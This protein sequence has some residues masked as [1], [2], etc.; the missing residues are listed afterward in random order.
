[1]KKL[2]ILPLVL[3]SLLVGC[4]SKDSL[5]KTLS[6]NPDILAE[7][8]KANPDE[9]VEALNEAFKAAQGSQGKKREEEEKKALEKSFE[10]PLI[11]EIRSDEMIRGSKDG[12]IVVVEY[13]DFE[14]PFCGR[15]Y[16]TVMELMDKYKGKVKFIYKHLPLSFHPNAM[17]A[18][19]YYEA[20]RLQSEDKAAK[21]HDELYKNQRK[22]QG[23]EKYL[24]S[25]VKKVGAN[26]SKIE[27]DRKSSKVQERIKE[28]MAEAAKYGF[29]GTPGFLV[30]GVPVKG[31]YP[32]SH[33]ENIIKELEKRGKISL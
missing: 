31:A 4:T 1:M 19:E 7:A 18:S 28:D 32:I 25:L 16:T 23:G 10:T 14:C 29:Q 33:F 21:F 6:E 5:K 17:V 30:N 22:L 15:A 12:P 13:S 20:I 3:L 9:I 24:K 2:V 11:A 27:K 8:I 26:Q